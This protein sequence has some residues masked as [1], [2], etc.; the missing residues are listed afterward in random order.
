MADHIIAAHT[1][2]LLGFYQVAWATMVYDNCDTRR[3]RFMKDNSSGFWMEHPMGM[4]IAVIL[5]TMGYVMAKNR[6]VMSEIQ[7]AFRYFLIALVLILV[8]TPGLSVNSLADHGFQGYNY[9]PQFD[10]FA[11][12]YIFSVN[13]KPYKG[14]YFVPAFFPRRR[15][16]VQTIELVIVNDFQ[17]M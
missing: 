6:L 9:F 3:N 4:L 12:P 15:I 2:A 7:K 17:N 1:T 10:Y 13:Y 14:S 5:I 11:I 8:S 16:Y